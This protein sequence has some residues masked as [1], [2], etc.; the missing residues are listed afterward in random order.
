MLWSR[1]S[2]EEQRAEHGRHDQ[3]HP[4]GGGG[5]QARPGDVAAQLGR[6]DAQEG[7]RQHHDDGF[8]EIRLD[9]GGERRHGQADE[10]RGRRQQRAV[11]AGQS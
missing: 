6:I 7:E 1:P 8:A 3:H 10:D 11:A 9:G 5:D 2:D 4:D